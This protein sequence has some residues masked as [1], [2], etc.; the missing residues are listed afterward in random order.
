[1]GNHLQPAA[2]LDLFG[3]ENVFLWPTTHHRAVL[4]TSIRTSNSPAPIHC[5]VWWEH[6]YTKSWDRASVHTCGLT[7]SSAASPHTSNVSKN[8]LMWEN[9]DTKQNIPYL[10]T[11]KSAIS[12]LT[13]SFLEHT[14]IHLLPS[15]TRPTDYIWITTWVKMN[16]VIGHTAVSSW[17]PLCQAQESLATSNSA[18]VL[19]L[20]TLIL[21]L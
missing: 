10:T 4:L 5:W 18:W 14:C 15:K 8:R 21:D 13:L 2:H 12:N 20:Y 7:Q 9:S 6:P 17:G 11:P 3:T 16:M 1:M 19:A